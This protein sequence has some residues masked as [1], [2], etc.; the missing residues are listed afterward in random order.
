[1]FFIKYINIKYKNII[2]KKLKTLKEK[3]LYMHIYIK[4]NMI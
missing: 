4:K 2:L 3:Y 1:M